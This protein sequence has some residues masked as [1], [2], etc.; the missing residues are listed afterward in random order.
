MLPLG[1]TP[2]PTTPCVQESVFVLYLFLKKKLFI[3]S[4]FKNTE[5]YPE[6]P[7]EEHQS[8]SPSA[9]I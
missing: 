7:D 9:P 2:T 5:H 4:I 3:M 1:L 6:E 8:D